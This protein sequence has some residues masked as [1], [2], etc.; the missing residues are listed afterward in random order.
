MHRPNAQ[1]LEERIDTSK[2]FSRVTNIIIL[3]LINTEY[4]INNIKEK[5]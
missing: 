2:I 1:N 4:L 3:L 5:F